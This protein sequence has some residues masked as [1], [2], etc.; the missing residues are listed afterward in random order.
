M[1]DCVQRMWNLLAQ[2][3]GFDADKRPCFIFNF[4]FQIP[5]SQTQQRLPGAD[6]ST[7]WTSA[8]ADCAC[9]T[10]RNAGTPSAV[11]PCP[12]SASWASAWA[13]PSYACHFLECS[14]AVPP[15]QYCWISFSCCWQRSV[16]PAAPLLWFWPDL[17]CSCFEKFWK[18]I[19]Y[20]LSWL[21]FKRQVTIEIKQT[22][23]ILFVY[24]VSSCVGDIAKNT[25]QRQTSFLSQK[26]RDIK[27]ENNNSAYTENKLIEPSSNEQCEHRRC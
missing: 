21:S 23:L 9:S 11:V 1:L 27:C 6:E 17:W 10:G 24:F 22:K 7:L 25:M 26:W 5:R 14:T 8:N 13:L 18:S 12:Y 20:H 2:A 3:R 16:W 4:F 19:S 15:L